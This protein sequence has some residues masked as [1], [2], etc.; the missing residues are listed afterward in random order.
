MENKFKKE[1]NYLKGFMPPILS[2]RIF[3]ETQQVKLKTNGDLYEENLN[4]LKKTNPIQFKLLDK[5]YENDLKLLT[6]RKKANLLNQTNMLKGK[7]IKFK[8]NNDNNKKILIN[9]RILTESTAY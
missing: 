9:K 1:E 3:R 5:F 8:I 6:I 7:K 2:E 4:I